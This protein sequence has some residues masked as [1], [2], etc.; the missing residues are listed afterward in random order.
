[1]KKLLAFILL[2]GCSISQAPAAVIFFDLTGTAGPGLLPGN[3]PGAVTGGTGGEILGGISF[4]NV[5]NLLSIN[6]GW[7]SS[8]GFTNLTSASNNSHIHGPTAANNG[9]GFTQTA[10]VL[11]DLT[12]SSNLVTGG[13]ITQS[14]SLTAPQSIDLLNGRFYINIHTATNGGGEMRGFIVPSPVP[15]P[16]ASLLILLAAGSILHRRGVTCPR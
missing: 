15:E 10:G 1:M 3:E 11:F 9:N 16:A 2:L 12:R 5:S 14:V 6:V 8:Q 7:G 4:D 13:T